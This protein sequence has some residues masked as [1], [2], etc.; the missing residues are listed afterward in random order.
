MASE[1]RVINFFPGP[2]TLPA[3]VL[4]QAAKEMLNYKGMGLGVMEMSHRSKA[5]ANICREAENDIRSLVNIPDN[6]K[7][8]FLQGGCSGMF[9]AVPLNFLSVNGKADYIVTGTW[10]SKAAVEAEKYGNVNLVLPK[11][12]KYVGVPPIEEWKLSDDAD[13]VYYC[14]NE[15]VGGVEFNFIPEVN[16]KPLICDMSSNIMT[17]DIDVT[18]FACIVAGAQKLMGPAGVTVVIIRDDMLGKERKECPTI[19]NFKKQVDAESRLNTP[20]CYSIYIT[21]LVLKYML[22]Q[23]GISFFEERNIRK[24]KLLYSTI[25]E[26]RGFY[27]AIINKDSQ[28]RVNVPFRVGGP[29][30]DERV[31]KKFV[32]EAKLKGLDGLAGHRSVGGCRASIYNVITFEDVE[33]LCNFMKEFQTQNQN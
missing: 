6:Y 20:P 32:E 10:S 23:G 8:L 21:G 19:W 17:R 7:V 2:S 30:G 5:F 25:L 33:K 26:S 12:D 16:G 4:H 18:K 31:E 29:K 11:T 13:Y 27:N 14:S 28:S 9:A 24:A 3:E 22:K 1:G 15:T